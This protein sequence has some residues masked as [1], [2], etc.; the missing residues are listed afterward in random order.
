[1]PGALA[2]T[3]RSPTS[4]PASQHPTAAVESQPRSRPRLRSGARCPGRAEVETAIGGDRPLVQAGPGELRA[5]ERPLTRS[6]V[7]E[8]GAAEQPVTRW[9]VTVRRVADLPAEAGLAVTARMA[10]V[11]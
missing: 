1:M 2:L 4:K 6:A 3:A 11:A 8:P 9:R 5:R 7:A 10:E